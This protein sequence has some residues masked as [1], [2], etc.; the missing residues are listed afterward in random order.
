MR[1][2]GMDV[3]PAAVAH[4]YGDLLDGLIIDKAD[5]ALAKG[6]KGPGIHITD[7]IMCDQKDKTRLAG[8]TVRFIENLRRCL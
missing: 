6:W 5:E 7:T 2:L 4:F 1:E 8:E 3:S